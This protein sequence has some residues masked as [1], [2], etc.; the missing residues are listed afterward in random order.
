[1][2]NIK[3]ENIGIQ[4]KLQAGAVEIFTDAFSGDPLFKFAFPEFKQR[5]R[6]TKIM[7]EFVVYD[8]VPMLDL[9][10]K[11]ATENDELAG[12]I[13][14]T[15]PDSIPWSD[16][17]TGSLERMRA[18]ASDEKINLIGQFA[19]L[20]GYKPK[21]PY[22]YVNELAVKKK[23]RRLGFG[24]AL[25]NN[26]IEISETHSAAKGILIDTAKENNLAIYEKFGWVLKSTI[27]FY[28]INKFFLWRE[29]K[30][31]T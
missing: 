17:M 31:N 23:F 5:K 21:A 20:G 4:E 10:I 1:M 24:K 18:K 25:I 28:D 26:I 8:M 6:L 3:I 27:P 7:Y 12:C 19:M 29:N 16:S 2:K 9:T 22:L 14:Y 15:S 13:I 11:G 30:I